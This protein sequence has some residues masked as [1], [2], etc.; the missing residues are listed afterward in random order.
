MRLLKANAGG[1]LG[2]KLSRAMARTLAK[3]ARYSRHVR[4]PRGI[5][6]WLPAGKP[7]LAAGAGGGTQTTVATGAPSARFG[8][9]VV[10][11]ALI[12]SLATYVILTGLTPILPTSEV[13]VSVLLADLILLCL[14]FY[15][16]LHELWRLR[17]ARVR[18]V[19][20]AR[21]HGQIV[22]LFS[23]I[24]VLPAI[25]LAVFSSAS[26]NRAMASSASRRRRTSAGSVSS[27]SESGH[28]S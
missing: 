15:V 18:Q 12:S 6:G 14:L 2:R 19:A 13:V 27:V 20:G 25:I 4:L 16:V 24:A 21:L 26:L 11:L 22:G 28:A 23:I 1:E 17:Q 3:G 7:A 5:R 9:G 10:I 8:L